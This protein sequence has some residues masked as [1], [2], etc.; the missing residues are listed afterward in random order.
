MRALDKIPSRF[1]VAV[2]LAAALGLAPHGHA[3][4]VAS[5][6][7][8][9]VMRPVQTEVTDN[10]ESTGT[11]AASATANIV[12]RVDGLLES[13]HFADGATVKKGERLFSIQRDTYEQ[14]L[15][16]YQ[17]QL[18]QAESEYARQL[19]LISQ[20]ATSQTRVESWRA[21]RDEAAANTELAK[22]NLG[23]TE[24]SAPFSGP[25]GRRLVD[26]GNLVGPNTG[27]TQLAVLQRVDPIF[28]Y[29]SIN[30]PDATGMRRRLLALEAP[31][32]SQTASQPGNGPVHL[33]LGNEADYRYAG[34]LDFVDTGIDQSSGT[35]QLRAVFDNPDGTFVPGQFGR[36]RIGLGQP[37]ARLAVP[38]RAVEQDQAG[39]YVLVVD[40]QDVV[41]Q[42]RVQTGGQE[43]DLRIVTGGLSP[44]ERVI[45]KGLAYA[46]PG[47]KVKVSEEAK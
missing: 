33:A 16:L 23:Y 30:A 38:N 2:V 8:V 24:I 43:G 6:D 40:E 46:Q 28:F 10:L 22:I 31:E 1:T 29:F 44:S 9:T 14:Q 20:D 36:I 11:F 32:G 21:K 26:P 47:R 15:K 17:A 42:R 41:R 37:V 18:S 3:Q 4:H 5:P 25:I 12:A 39:A 13:V 27:V 7:E 34:R 35:I 19:R 45:I